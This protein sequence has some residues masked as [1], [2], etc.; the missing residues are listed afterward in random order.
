MPY[1][2]R[3]SSLPEGVGSFEPQPADRDRGAAS[4]SICGD[5]KVIGWNPI[6]HG[7]FYEQLDEII[8]TEVTSSF[9]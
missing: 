2:D 9:G 6:T 8:F 4:G 7:A 5:K 3:I 1:R